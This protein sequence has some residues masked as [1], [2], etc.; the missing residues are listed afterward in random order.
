MLSIKKFTKGLFG[1]PPIFII[2]LLA[3]SAIAQECPA[4]MVCITRQAAITA[5]ENAEKVKALEAEGKAKDQDIADQKDVISKLK[6]EYAEKVGE[7]IALK[8]N[9][10][11]DRE[12]INIL[13]KGQRK[14][15]MPLSICF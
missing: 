6:V 5:V 12:I 8:Q 9:A 10:V 14:K 3:G 7:N 11:S 4:D 1:R 2:L 13:I 15:C